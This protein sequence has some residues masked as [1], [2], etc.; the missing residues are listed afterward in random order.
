MGG[1]ASKA[2]LGACPPG[3]TSDISSLPSPN[4]SGNY[5]LILADGKECESHPLKWTGK[6]IVIGRSETQGSTLRSN[7]DGTSALHLDLSWDGANWMVKVSQWGLDMTDLYETVKAPFLR[8][9]P[10]TSARLD[11]SRTSSLRKAPV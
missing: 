4:E 11:F 1:G 3:F 9:H 5:Q 2:T 6:P 8:I 7:D 10:H